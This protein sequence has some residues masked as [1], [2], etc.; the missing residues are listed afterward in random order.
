MNVSSE[1]QQCQQRQLTVT[2]IDD[3]VCVA[4]PPPPCSAG[5]RC[6]RW[7]WRLAVLSVCFGLLLWA[8]ALGR[9]VAR[10]IG[11]VVD[12]SLDS[13]VAWFDR[14]LGWSVAPSDARFP[15]IMI[16]N[17]PSFFNAVFAMVKPMLNESTKKKID[18]LPLATAGKEMLKAIPSENLPP[19]YGG[20]CEVGL[21]GGGEGG[22]GERKLDGDCPPGRLRLMLPENTL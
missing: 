11:C 5:V 22:G 13:L 15:Q 9:L 21:L 17:A 4:P 7:R 16:L 8:A 6:S 3:G 14:S 19:H 2:S 12:L 20:T 18:L 1:R 10:L